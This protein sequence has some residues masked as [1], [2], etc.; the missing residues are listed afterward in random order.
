MRKLQRS[1]QQQRQINQSRIKR[2]L[3]QC[4]QLEPRQLMAS[5]LSEFVSFSSDPNHPVNTAQVSQK[6]SAPAWQTQPSTHSYKTDGTEVD[7]VIYPN[8]LAVSFTTDTVD[9][10]TLENL[11]LTFV[12][13]VNN[14]FSVY[15]SANSA[16]ILATNTSVD[17][18]VP[19]FFLQ[20]SK[21]EAVLLDE[22]I[23]ALKPG[24]TAADYFTGNAAFSGYRPLVG[25]PDQF[26]ATVAAGA[27]EVALATMNAASSD[28]RLEWVAPNFYQTW[29]K[30]YTPNDPRF[31]NLW[32]LNNTG[33]SGGLV[34]ADSDLPEAWDVIR[35]N[36]SNPNTGVDAY[37]VGVIDDG[38]VTNHPDLAIWTNPGEIAGDLIDNDG[39]GWVD[40]IN[41]WNFVSNNN[42][43]GNTTADDMHGTSVAGVAAARGDNS[44]GVTGA[45]YNAKVISARMFEGALVASDANIAGALYYMAGRT[46]NGLGTW[47]SADLVNN[48]WGGGG[49][50]AAINAALTYGT[51]QGRLGKGTPYLFAT[52]NGFGAVSQPAVQSLNIPGVFAIGATNNGGIRSDYSNFGP[53][54]DMVTPSNDTRAGYLAIDTTD[55]VGADGYAAG[56]YTGT[57]ATGFGGTS[58][59]TPLAT[60]ITTLAMAQADVLGVVMTPAQLRDY[61]RTNTDLIGGATY[62]PATGKNLEFGFGRLNAA[63][64]VSNIGKAEISVLSST[65]DLISGTSTVSGANT[66][67]GESFDMTFR[68]RNQG[69][70]P[71]NLSSLAVAAGPFTVQTGLGSSTL[72]IGGA[73][74]FVLRFAPTAGGTFTRTVTIGSND[75]NEGSFT[76]NVSAQGVAPSIGGTVFEDWDGDSAVD[77]QDIPRAGRSVFL[78]TNNN[79]T[80]DTVPVTFTNT[81]P[82]TI[83]DQA[84]VTSTINVAGFANFIADVNVTL[85]ITHTYNSDLQLT[86]ISPA[87]VRVLLFSGVGGSGDNFVNTVLDDEATLA[88]GGGTAPFTNSY[89]PASALSAFDGVS[90]NGTWT[91]EVTDLAGGDTGTL[92]NWTLN[93]LDGERSTASRANGGYAFLGLPAATYNVRSLP[94]TGWSAS[95]ANLYTVNVTAPTDSLTGRDFGSGVNNRFY[96][97]VFNDVNTDGVFQSNEAPQAGRFIYQDLNNNGVLDGGIATFTNTTPLTITDVGTVNSLMTVGGTTGG[98][99]DVNVKVNITMSFNADLDVFLVHPDGTRVELFTDVGGSSANFVNTVLDDQA[100]TSIATGTGPFTGSFRPEGSL[101]ALNGKLANGQWR[102]ELTDDAGGD[103]GTLNNWELTLATGESSVTTSALG[104]T[105]FDLPAGAHN[106]RLNGLAGWVPTLPS[107]ALRS[108]TASGAPL[109]DQR[110]GTKLANVAPTLTVA[111]SAVSGNEGTTLVNNGTW[112]DV[113]ASDVVTLS[114]SIGTV[115]KNANGTW[116]WSHSAADNIPLT[117][118]TITAND[119]QGG[120]TSANFTFIAHNVAPNVAAASAAVSGAVFTT[121][122]NTGT[123]G[124]VPADT[125]VLTAS[126][127]TLVNHNNGTWSW[128]I[129]PT[130]V[131]TNQVVTITATDDDGGASTTTFTLNATAAVSGRSVFYKGSGFQ[132]V[133]GVAAAT[134]ST[135]VILQSSSVAQTTNRNNVSNYTR[136]INGIVL[137]VA[138]LASSTLSASDFVFR[139]APPGASGV[140]NPSTWANAPAPSSIS[141]TAGSPSRIQLEWADNVIQNTWLQIIVRANANTGLGAN[142]AFYFGSAA[143]DADL[144]SAGGAYRIGV[145]DLSAVQGAISSALVGINNSLDIDKNRRV[146]IPDLSFVQGRISAT[147]ILNDITIPAAGSASEGFGTS[148]ASGKGSSDSLG[149]KAPL[150]DSNLPVVRFGTSSA[151]S[152]ESGVISGSSSPV[153]SAPATTPAESAGTGTATI[154]KTSTAAVDDFFKDLGDL[155][156]D[157]KSKIRVLR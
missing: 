85:N 108:V 9:A 100:A 56:D 76:F 16:A 133:G 70:T 12:R 6:V 13:K 60:G 17:K 68:V 48:S 102:L 140:V 25:T 128:S 81:T 75:A 2:M 122:T 117:T 153:I 154:S 157:L 109:F 34:D 139:V 36:P 35:S 44:L 95:G 22:V 149:L 8:R 78:D 45:A 66:F 111:N 98:I 37:V 41:G 90:A 146:G 120:I 116:N 103:V 113:N 96:G 142:T 53:A 57:G 115:V 46:A 63:S 38:V 43:S 112:G 23:V 15:D 28:A 59:A 156:T 119:G 40:D 47:K 150:V 130:A 19:V 125:I 147:A 30:F 141:V 87:G 143:G 54:V 72:G 11:Q 88:I 79:G 61:L 124:D 110:F 21:S 155:T 104:S 101:A 135:K 83:L 55:R 71:L 91:L 105:T 131:V 137:E 7:M 138:G 20:E 106:M 151:G 89:R 127:G 33:Q 144:I 99:L 29:Q 50:S 74:T 14:D 94:P 134:D 42:Q 51:T 107:D 145:P 65:T 62:D 84:T 80:L 52:G 123:H 82:R 31:T 114:A 136:G 86:L 4:E 39:N 73:T 129:V 69:T 121:I 148:N 24:V 27:G 64:A 77:P 1:L 132:S 18:V 118:V 58:S 126:H 93:F 67:V 10:A 5:D 32:H 3:L 97:L 49:N 26:V 152:P 92:N